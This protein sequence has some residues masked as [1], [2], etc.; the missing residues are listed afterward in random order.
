MSFADIRAHLEGK[1]ALITGASSGVGQAT[2]LEFAK[3]GVRVVA[4]ARRGE[5]LNALVESIRANGACAEATAGNAAEPATAAAAL[6]LCLD[7]FGRIDFLINSAGQGNY[8]PFLETTLAEYDELIASNL[9]SSF[10]FS[11]EAAPH[12]V[13]Q[14]SGTIVFVSSVAGLRGTGNEA[15]YSA[16]KFAQIGFSQ[17]LDDELRPFGVKVCTLCPGGI[18]TEF[19]IGKGRTAEGVAASGMMD[20]TDVADTI[21]FLCAQ[22]PNVRIVQATIRNMGQQK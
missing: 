5:R 16:S 13:R 14:R 3:H 19:A 15:V 21:L 2:A 7:R 22:P 20:A 17:A 10:L 9:R 4:T 8:K 11:R 6:S 12:M 1:V 18:K